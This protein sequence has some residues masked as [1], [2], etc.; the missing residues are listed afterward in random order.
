MI[1][2]CCYRVSNTMTCAFVQGVI[3]Y[4]Y[5]LHNPNIVCTCLKCPVLHVETKYSKSLVKCVC[6]YDYN[7]STYLCTSV[8]CV[9]VE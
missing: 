4:K 5:I 1:R 3:V 2:V 6:L 7:M 9:V 8:H